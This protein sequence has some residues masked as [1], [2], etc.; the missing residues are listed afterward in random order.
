MTTWVA[1]GLLKRVVT[2]HWPRVDEPAAGVTPGRPVAPGGAA[3]LCPTGALRE[4]TQEVRLERCVHCARC[5]RVE[6]APAQWCDDFAWARFGRGR[7][8]LPAAFV[9]SIHVRVVDAGDCS[10]CLAELLQL[11]SPHYSLHRLGIF[12][13]PTPRQADVLLVVG[14]VSSA[15]RKP[16][17]AAYTAMPEP[18]RV[19]AVG[20]CAASGGLFG[21][22][23]IC[24]AGAAGTVPVDIVV[25]G[26][27]PPPLAILDALL[28]VM[29]RAPADGV[30]R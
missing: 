11:P 26:C 12:L 24:D 16:L 21:P 14:P 6:T 8:P 15:M 2:T 10:A 30:T 28:K 19:V 4:G 29:G 5:T 3:A 25:P 27:P 20:A 18:K 17:L 1:K 23:F 9:R 7:T 22:S 13:T